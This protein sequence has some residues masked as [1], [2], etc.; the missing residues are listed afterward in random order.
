M[1]VKWPA[2]PEALPLTV[3]PSEIDFSHGISVQ[4]IVG[5]RVRGATLTDKT[6][7]SSVDTMENWGSE[8]INLGQPT[9]KV[10]VTAELTGSVLSAV[11]VD[12]SGR[13]Q[14][15]IS[16]DSGASYDYGT[17]NWASGEATGGTRRS[18]CTASHFISGTPTGDIRVKAQA[19][20]SG[21]ATTDLDFID[22]TIT[23]Q[24][25]PDK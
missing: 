23:A 18:A 14:V 11:G 21:G 9:M 20:I 13:V 2:L 6:S 5:V 7:F 19:L 15:G 24:M 16:L 1:T 17:D 3:D 10:F 22:G 12:S 8:T 25:A 4:T